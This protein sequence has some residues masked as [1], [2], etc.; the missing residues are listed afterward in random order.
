MLLTGAI[1]FAA[2]AD[3]QDASPIYGVRLPADYRQ[4]QV[5][6]VAHEAGSL[7][8]IRVI[9]GND[10]AVAAYRNGQRPF[11]DGTVLVRVAWKLVPSPRNDAIFGRA[12]SFV[13]GEPTNVQVEV[14]NSKL[15]GATGGWGYGQFE[16]GKANP[17]AA[18]IGTCNACHRKLADGDDLVFTHYSP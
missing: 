12:Q 2:S 3:Q 8:D 1:S 16:S 13:A 6:S 15:Y 14:K 9:L 7:N 5:I 10:I 18:L 11:P 4:W 17:D